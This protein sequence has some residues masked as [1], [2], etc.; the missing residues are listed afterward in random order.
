MPAFAITFLDADGRT[1]KAT[2]EAA[3]ADEL[4]TRLRAQKFWPVRIEPARV[5][6]GFARLRVPV[7]DFIAVLH[8]LELQLRAGVTADVALAQL[9]EDS[10]APLGDMLRHIHRAVAQGQPIHA[11]C[12][13]FSRMFPAHLAAVIAAGE[14]SAQL[15]EALRALAGHLSSADELRKTAKR[16]LI[17]PVIVLVA[18]SALILFLVGGV[19]PQFA[20]IF[21]SLHVTLPWLTR[22]LIATSGALHEHWPWLLAG[23]SALVVTIGFSLRT[24]RLKLTRDRLLLLLPVWGDTVRH[25]A[26]A[27]FAAHCRLLH[28]AGL[29]L[30]ETLATGAE[31]TGNAVLAG[32]LLT[33]RTGV[34][35]GKPL[36]ASLPK[37]HA[38]PGFVLPALKAGETTGQLG[39]A[40][41]HIEDYAASRA[42]ERLATALALLEP[43]LLAVLTG[44]V[45][46][47]ALSFFLPLFSLMGGLNAR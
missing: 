13:Y 28:Q 34:A 36:Y 35:A 40:L 23:L 41:Q 19:V 25:L 24:P 8:Q 33:A 21:T 37:P 38:F 10:P 6:P 39:A 20:A 14:A 7:R 27:R 18:T 1:R 22:A 30:L 4:R 26:T 15:P 45:G 12:R 5:R 17:Y 11:A 9:A 43:A 47:I 44:V 2:H 31:L 42:K 16:A 29:P 32:Q 3:D 46:L